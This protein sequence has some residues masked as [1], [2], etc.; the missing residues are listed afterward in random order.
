M[1]RGWKLNRKGH[2]WRCTHHFSPRYIHEDKN[3]EDGDITQR[4]KA[5]T[6]LS[7]G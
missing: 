7:E 3:V 4:L 5:H 2:T 1:Q 6:V